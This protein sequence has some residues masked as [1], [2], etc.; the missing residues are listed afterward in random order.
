MKGNG[1]AAD[2]VKNKVLDICLGRAQEFEKLVDYS[3]EA[4]VS[5]TVLDKPAGTI[6]LFAFDEGQGLSEHTAPYDA[7]VVVV[8]GSAKLTIG[9]KEQAVC[10]GQI[11]IMPADVPH[12]VY[13][14]EKFKMMLVM[15]RSQ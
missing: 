13:A 8:D 1:M 6:T 15:I 2:N 3:P 11:I 14:H 9:G 4:I 7:V 5:K 12:S 10:A